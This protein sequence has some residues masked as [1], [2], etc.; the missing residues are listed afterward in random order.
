M[1]NTLGRVESHSNIINRGIDPLKIAAD[2]AT[3]SPTAKDADGE[4]IMLAKY[5]D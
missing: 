3:A 2:V 4:P 1:A 5:V